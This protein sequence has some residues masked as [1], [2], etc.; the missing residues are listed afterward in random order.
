MIGSRC[1]GFW[2][3][4]VFSAL[5][6]IATVVIR[7][8]RS[9][10][11]S[12]VEWCRWEI[13]SYWQSEHKAFFLLP[14]DTKHTNSPIPWSPSQQE[15]T[16]LNT[17]SSAITQQCHKDFFLKKRMMYL[18]SFLMKRFPGYFLRSQWQVN[19]LSKTNCFLHILQ[20]YMCSSFKTFWTLYI[21][22][23]NSI[24]LGILDTFWFNL[25][26]H[27]DFGLVIFQ[28]GKIFFCS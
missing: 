25:I 12:L 5:N 22:W 7:F 2:W 11:S 28:D 3:R 10:D 17:A 9:C 4:G 20:P 15:F 1:F 16:T 6:K 8:C 18:S 23:L 14:S 26:L 21:Q 13:A 24:T 19:R 27:P